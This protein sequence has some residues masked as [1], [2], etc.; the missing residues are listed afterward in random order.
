MGT[1]IK[2]VANKAGVSVSTVSRAFTRP[3][4]VSKATRAKVLA[5]AEE[6]NFSISRSAMVLKSGRALRVA[7]LMSDHI[8]LWFS[9]SIIEGLNQVFHANGY[10]LSIFQI[11]S[12]EERREFFDMLPIRRNAD[13]VI[14]ASFDIDTDE[15]SQLVTVGV[16]IVGINCVMPTIGFNAAV[17]IDDD[18]GSKLLARHLIGLGHR[19]IAYVRTDRAVTLHFSVQQRYESFAQVCE[20]SGIDLTT[21]VI[22]D[23]DDRISRATTEL[24][25]MD[26][27]PTAIA[28]QEDGIAIPLMF[29][30]ARTGLR[31]PF[32]VSMVGYDDSFYANEVGLTTVRQDPIAMATS[33]AL[34]ALDLIEQGKTA[35][36]FEVFP[37]QLLVR[38]STTEVKD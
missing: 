36:P 7:L 22:A 30:L 8:R 37:A 31:V 10:D 17:N 11:S 32:D 6:L 18:Q 27:M 5:I 12:I 9:A 19:R 1:N 2:D 21:I 28:C 33:A 23:G 24:L 14:V 34:K 4:L 29:Q 20:Q 3:E 16:P 15:I 26:R 13:A 38:S 25:S 35:K